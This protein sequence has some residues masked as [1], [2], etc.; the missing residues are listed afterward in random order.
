MFSPGVDSARQLAQVADVLVIIPIE[1]ASAA[2]IVQT[3]HRQHVPVL[4]YDGMIRG[5]APDAYL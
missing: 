4:G 1:D 3:A 5:A 2:P